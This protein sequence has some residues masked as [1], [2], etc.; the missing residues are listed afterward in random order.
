MAVALEKS[1]GNGVAGRAARLILLLAMLSALPLGVAG[2]DAGSGICN[3]AITGSNQAYSVTPSSTAFGFFKSGAIGNLAF[4][5]LVLM[6]I[7]AA[8]VYMVGYAFGI[9]KLASFGRTELGE[10]AITFILVAIFLGTMQ[11][12]NSLTTSS[13]STS[14]FQTGC[15]KLTNTALGMVGYIVELYAEQQMFSL[16]QSFSYDIRISAFG[17]GMEPLAGLGL[18]IFVI[19]QVTT[20]AFGL[21][22]VTLG[23]AVVFV[24]IYQIFPVFLYIGIILRT[25]PWSRAAGGA[26]LGLF[27]AFYILFPALF[28]MMLSSI[29]TPNCGTSCPTGGL[30]LG[31]IG[32]GTFP[33]TTSFDNPIGGFLNAIT[34][35]YNMEIIFSAM[36][37][38]IGTGLEVLFALVISFIISFDFMEAVGD[39]LGAPSLKSSNTLKKII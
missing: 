34:G 6:V 12:I 16:A 17:Y 28:L 35:G 22:G 29:S 3:G 15:T 18:L 10:V 26:F 23:A 11:S 33:S 1:I 14:S 37:T 24:A 4:I 30:N 5:I 39:L 38:V 31:G 19:G 13:G 7:V 36:Q 20:V 32:T 25:I 2:A 8:F 9:G 27:V 21:M